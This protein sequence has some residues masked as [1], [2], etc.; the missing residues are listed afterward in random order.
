MEIKDFEDVEKVEEGGYTTNEEEFLQFDEIVETQTGEP[1]QNS[2]IV[3]IGSDVCSLYPSLAAELTG[4]LVFE[5]ALNSKIEFDGLNFIE[6][7]TYLA[8]NMKDHEMRKSGISNL[9]PRRKHKKG[10]KPTI[11]GEAAMGAESTHHN[12]WFYPRIYF[13][14]EE[15]KILFA[16]CLQIGIVTLF[17]NHLYQFGGKTFRQKGGAPTGLRA[18]CPATRIVMNCFDKRLTTIMEEQG[19]TVEEAFR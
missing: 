18:S 3:I 12:H 8:I 17:E 11:T 5:A 1:R 14:V 9:L 4:E 15:K 2:D 13:T 16:K 19:L 6:I 7:V 10:C